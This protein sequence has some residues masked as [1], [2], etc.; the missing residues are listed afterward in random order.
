MWGRFISNPIQ[1]FVDLCSLCNVSVVILSHDQF[2]Y[3]IHGRTVHGFGDMS[4]KQ[5]HECL[6]REEVRVIPDSIETNSRKDD[7]KEKH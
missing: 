2:G 1:N 7:T 3:Y 4:L 5:M 6:K